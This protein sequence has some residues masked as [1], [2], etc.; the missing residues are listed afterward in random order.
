MVIHSIMP[1]D[2]AA[3]IRGS[4]EELKQCVQQ[5]EHFDKRIVELSIA[6]KALVR[7]AEASQREQILQEVQ[8]AR[9][10]TPS[11]GDAIFMLLVR[12]PEGLNATAIR[13]HLEN[14]G[15]P[16]E[17]YSQPLGAVMTAAQRLVESEKL[18]RE[19]TEES[20]VVFRIKGADAMLP[21]SPG[22]PLLNQVQQRL[23]DEK[24]RK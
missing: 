2:Y 17:E 22:V 4:R 9:R 21:G 5:R 20:G 1:V 10:K 13:E 15:F 18:T 3:V 12:N 6:L 7:F 16:I 23:E 8:N 19:T 14:S 11:L 24:K